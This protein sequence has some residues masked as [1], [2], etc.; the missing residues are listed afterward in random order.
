M[1]HF[2]IVVFIVQK[3]AFFSNGCVLHKQ[4]LALSPHCTRVK[5]AWDASLLS[6][7]RAEGCTQSFDHAVHTVCMSLFYC[8]RGGSCIVVRLFVRLVSPVDHWKKIPPPCPNTRPEMS[9]G[10]CHVINEPES[11]YLTPS[12][13]IDPGFLPNM[14]IQRCHANII[15]RFSSYQL[16]H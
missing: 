14:C 7:S 13:Q 15:K 4:C 5:A 1:H 2:K 10:C 16:H 11:G 12:A 9:R 8:C 6:S 3:L